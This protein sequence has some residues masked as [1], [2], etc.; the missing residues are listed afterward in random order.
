M[1]EIVCWLSAGEGHKNKEKVPSLFDLKSMESGG[2]YKDF[3]KLAEENYLPVP[4]MDFTKR[5][6]RV[7][8]KAADMQ[9]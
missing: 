8:I 9:R 2:L 4:E 3:L 6:I 7:W 1:S 5:R